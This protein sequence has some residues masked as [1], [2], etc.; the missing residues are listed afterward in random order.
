MIYQMFHGVGPMSSPDGRP[1]NAVFGCTRAIMELYDRGADYLLAAYDVSSNTFRDAIV[2]NYKANRA[3]PPIELSLQ[4]PMIR[5][6]LEAMRIPILE[7]PGYEADDVMATIARLGEEQGCVVYLCTSDKDCR[8]LLSPLTRIY[9]LRKKEELDAEKLYLDWGVHPDQVVDYQTLVGDSTDNVKGLTGCGAKTASKWLQQFGT[10]D[11]IVKNVSSIGGPK[12][13]QALIQWH[14]DGTLEQTRQL[15]RLERFVPIEFD[16]DGWKRRE[17][18]YSRLLDLF[19]EYG[20]RTFATKVRAEIGTFPTVPQTID[21]DF[22]FGA[23]AEVGTANSATGDHW[24]DPE[25]QMV[26]TP[27]HFE[28]F[29]Q[30]L[31][32][33]SFFTIDLETTS[34]DPFQ[35]KIVGYAISWEPTKAYYL[36]VRAPFGFTVLDPVETFARLRPILEDAK[37]QKSNQ[38]IKYDMLV[39]RVHGVT[40]RGVS[41]DPMIAD[42]LLHAGE[43]S[44]NLDDMT[45]RYYNHENISITEL[46]GQGK[47]QITIDQADLDRVTA[48]AGEDAVAAYKLTSKLE[49]ELRREKL[50]DLYHDIEIPLIRILLDMEY[51]GVL[52]DAAYLKQLSNEMTDQLN[53]LESAIHALAGRQFNISSPKQLREIMFEEL[54]YPIQKK[55][56]TTREASTDYETLEKLASLGYELPKRIIEYRSIAKLKGTYVDALPNLIQPS[57]GRVHTSL[58]QTVASTGRLS[59]SEPNLQNIPAR[60]D[61]GRQI[62]RA[63]IARPGWRIVTSDYSQIELRLLAHFCEDSA[64]LLAFEQNE[65][66]HTRVAAQIFKVLPTEVTSE[67]RRVAK[68]VNFGVIYG[69]SS[70]GLAVRLGITRQEADEF[71][72]GYFSQFP[73]VLEYQNALLVKAKHSG[74]V[75]TLLGRRRRFDPATIRE[76]STFQNRSQ[77]E[78]EAIN[79][80]IQGSAADLMKLAILAVDREIHKKNLNAKMIL[81]VH[82]ELVFEVPEDE[83]SDLARLARYEMTN[84]MKLKVPLQ[85]D[86]AVGLNWLDVTDYKGD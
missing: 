53:D 41:G 83:V 82:D 68:T 13:R 81:T 63:F 69:M 55:T 3:E 61:Q 39:L 29:F 77:A 59:S 50:W 73:R 84:V 2:D 15:V 38:N 33:Q 17:W 75:T 40:L 12:L 1:T 79:M 27:E 43:R 85:V 60:T 47:S 9:N 58:N 54:G 37:I 11:N 70:H 36:P 8:Q 32:R 14:A 45:R 23:F 66:V 30:E 71:I 44:H 20:F 4:H 52:I 22:P 57:T 67:Q 62:R 51:E 21:S 28:S 72:E 34:L 5:A 10:L 78:R 76:K 64:M 18:D 48:Y 25:Y 74:Y 49:G 7:Y 42:Y 26:S 46:I 6:V 35:A 16:W 86:I 65:D 31:T 80:E 56:G 19:T 24:G